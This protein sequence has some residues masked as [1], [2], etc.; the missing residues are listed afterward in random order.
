MRDWFLE[1][2]EI[3]TRPPKIIQ[4]NNPPR[5]HTE[6]L[7]RW[8]EAQENFKL[9]LKKCTDKLDEL[10]NIR[11]IV[12]EFESAISK[13]NLDISTAGEFVSQY[14]KL[15][16]SLLVC[17]LNFPLAI[18]WQKAY[19][20][21]QNVELF[22]E[23]LD[24]HLVTNQ[25]FSKTR[26]EIN[27]ISPWCDALT[28]TLRD[29]V[30]IESMKL[31]KAFIDAAA[32][33]LRH[34]IGIFM[35]F[36]GKQNDLLDKKVLD[37]MPDLWSSFFLAVPTVSTT[38]ASVER[39]LTYLPQNYLGWL[40]IDEAGQ[41]LPQAAVGAI[42][43]TKRAVIT[44]DPLQ[45][46]P[47]VR[48]PHSLTNSICRQFSVSISDFNAPTASVQTLADAATSYYTELH[49]KD[50]SRIVGF[51]LLV[52]RR[53]AEPMFS[54]SNI[55]AYERLMVH[56]KK[57]SVSLIYDCLGPSAWFDVQG[58]A[59]DKWSPEEG[60]KVLELLRKLKKS[61]IFPNLYIITPFK[62]I[63]NS[64]RKLIKDDGIMNY[65]PDIE[66][67]HWINERIGTI[68]T[69]Q[70]REAEAVIL[71]LGCSTE[72][73]RGTRVWAGSSPN[74]LN[75]AVT[76]ATEVIYVIG[77][78]VLWKEAGVFKELCDKIK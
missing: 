66:P 12:H 57:P 64:L 1:T 30:F 8:K 33:P 78:K 39:M 22:S 53:C 43:R 73:Q 3:K 34:N 58:H 31:S 17:I 67:Y 45:I 24:S 75:V 65:W 41:A 61:L 25:L 7:K 68:H 77:N 16:P 40:L 2:G 51:P 14:K 74:M 46:E 55:I 20:L 47:V 38:F 56:V 71:V 42:M 48:L 13:L 4:K 10:E 49:T 15:R 5:N 70:G 59:P 72:S 29:E 54:I 19:N 69:V 44:G 6:A 28:Q 35:K 27:Q 21:G 9:V 50:G 36:F 52:H 62:S 76:R 23:K 60:E 18:K 63:A 11:K 37:F 32:A 26:A